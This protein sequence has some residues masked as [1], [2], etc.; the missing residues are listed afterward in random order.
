MKYRVAEIGDACIYY[1]SFANEIGKIKRR[2]GRKL[3]WYGGDIPYKVR[4]LARLLNKATIKKTSHT[5]VQTTGR[6][7]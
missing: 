2:K 7:Y 4:I 1:L 6:E 3:N 5:V